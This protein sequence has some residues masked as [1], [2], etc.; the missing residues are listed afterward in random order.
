MKLALLGFAAAAL[1]AANDNAPVRQISNTQQMDFP[2]G[3]TLRMVNST[4]ELTVEGWD[5]PQ[6]EITTIKKTWD[7]SDAPPNPNAAK[8]LEQVQIT[9]ERKG[10]EIVVTTAMP[11]KFFLVRPIQGESR[12]DV[13]YRIHIPHAARLAIDHQLGEIHIID[14]RGEAHVSAHKGQITL[15]LPPDGHY[16]IDAKSKLGVIDS[17]FPGREQRKLKFGHTFLTEGS[18]AGQKL[19]L[20]MGFGDIT[21]LA[22]RTPASPGPL[23][24]K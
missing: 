5:R 13:E 20:R 8:E 15:Y 18:T 11:K 3:G 24:Q 2:S 10:D 6:I 1:M 16:A 17:D 19:Y 4:G 12:Y 23:P 7:E 9:T 21:I 14:V 22:M